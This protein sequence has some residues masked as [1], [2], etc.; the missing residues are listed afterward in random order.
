MD[1]VSDEAAA[2][3]TPGPRRA[4]IARSGSELDVGRLYAAAEPDFAR[5]E[6]VKELIDECIDLSLN[7]RQ[8]G[9]TLAGRGLRC[10]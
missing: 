2:S 3:G 5:Y 1:L 7:Y 8:S 10:T 4:A 9:G 6:L